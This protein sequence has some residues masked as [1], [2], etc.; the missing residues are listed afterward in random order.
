MLRSKTIRNAWEGFPPGRGLCTYWDELLRRTS[1][2]KCPFVRRVASAWSRTLSAPLLC[3]WFSFGV[4]ALIC[5]PTAQ[6]AAVSPA[7]IVGKVLWKGALLPADAFEVEED[8]SACAPGG[9]LVNNCVEIDPTSRGVRNAVVWLD[10]K[11]E[12]LGNEELT[13]KTGS[14]FEF[15]RCQIE[16]SLVLV[17][18]G[19]RVVFMNLDSVIHY[20]E[21]KAS[22]GVSRAFTLPALGSS[23]FLRPTELGFYE[24]R[25]KRHPWESAT[26]VVA[27]HPYYTVTDSSGRFTLEGVSPGV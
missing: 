26:I 2:G 15:R 6:G 10:P 24:V 14:Q 18:R 9:T 22:K 3:V 12:Q 7:T 8:V 21:V 4:G 1:F 11:P 27:D 5:M 23:E 19:T 17:S 25:C 16:P 13:N 20:V